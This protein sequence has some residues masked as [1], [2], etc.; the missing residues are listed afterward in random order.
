MSSSYHPQS[1]GQTER[2]NQC[3]E[4]FLRCYVHTC[5]S[6]WSAWLSVA[7]YWY[8]TTVHSTLGRTPFEVLYGH[9]PR[10]FGILVDIV[11]PQPEL[12]TWLKERELMTKVIKLHLHRA[13]DRMKRQADK[14]RSE[15]VF[16][17]GD[18]VYLKLQPYI[19]SSVATRS[20]H[21]LSFKFFGPFQ[22]T[23]VWVPWLTV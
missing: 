1:D 23:I 19:Q 13:Q 14:Q 2:L 3:L 21:K 10:Y 16:S 12:E 5:P 6:R 7:E 4:T 9:T 20:N 17:V 15:R 11:V 8:N 22:I 18:W